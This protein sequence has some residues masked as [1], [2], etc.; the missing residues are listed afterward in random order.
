M[1]ARALGL[2]LGFAADRAFADPSRWHPVA[3]FGIV[4]AASERNLYADRRAFGI[5]HTASL[6]AGTVVLGSAAERATRSQPFADTLITAAATWT[7]LGGRSL[8]REA[9]AIAD[10][11]EARDLPGARRRLTHLVARETSGLASEQIARAVVE[12]VAENTSDAVVAPLIWGAV[13][14]VPGLLGYRAVNTLDAMVGYRSPRYRNFGWAAARLDDLLNLPASRIAALLVCVADPQRAKD[15]RRIWARDAASHPSPNAGVVEAAFAG[16][17]GIRLGGT[18]VYH[19]V[20]EH[21][22]GLGDGPDPAV[23]DIVR[24]VGL[25]RR[26]GV[27]AALLAIVVGAKLDRRRSDSLQPPFIGFDGSRCKSGTVAPL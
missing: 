27:A 4:A 14:G 9:L 10:L 21:R 24:T 3:G 15:S 20:T 18:N 13:A 11:L 26:I 1:R 25:A 22:A 19:G 16:S 7:V 23:S 8:E 6:V 12:S 5:L 2:L 17:L